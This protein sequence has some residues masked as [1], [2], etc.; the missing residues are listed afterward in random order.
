[1]SDR[2]SQ[3]SR[4]HAL[5]GFQRVLATIMPREEDFFILFQQMSDS[6][7]EATQVLRDLTED[8][9]R[10]DYAVGKVDELEHRGDNLVHEIVD[11]LNSTFVTPLLMDREDILH[12][13]EFIDNVTD[14]VKAVVDRFRVYEIQEATPAARRLAG[15]LT[16]AAQLLRDNM[17]ALESLQPGENPY[18]ARINELENQGDALLKEALGTMFREETDAR[19]IIKWK[20]LYEMM[21]EALDDCED[22]ANLV[23]TL[24]VKNA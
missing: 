20:D 21:E 4:R 2:K 12:L 9:S 16:Q 23:E 13:A 24:V 14:H 8:I 5:S 10:L 1:M 6:T 19:N 18:C 22:A 3:A 17:H 11:R 15:L 7:L